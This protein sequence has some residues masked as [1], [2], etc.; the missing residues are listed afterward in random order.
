MD[1]N[2]LLHPSLLW[3]IAGVVVMFLELAAPGFVIFFFGIGC[4]AVAAA[5]LFWDPS[6]TAQVAIFLGTS[7]VT[8]LLLRRMLLQAFQGRADSLT[9]TDYDDFPHNARV[10]VVKAISPGEHGRV[11]YRGTTWEAAADE[12]IAEDAT[13]EI[14]DFADN[15]H[16]VFKVRKI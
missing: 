4:W 5:L 11:S 14:L 3:F 12:A 2:S 1:S 13:V 8:L 7:V 15:S 9:Q 10:K 16:L 6:P